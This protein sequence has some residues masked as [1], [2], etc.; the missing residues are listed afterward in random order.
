[1]ADPGGTRDPIEQELTALRHTLSIERSLLAEL[2]HSRADR[3]RIAA[4]RQAVAVL[5]RREAELVSKLRG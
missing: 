4:A 1:M 2:E 3:N 5:E